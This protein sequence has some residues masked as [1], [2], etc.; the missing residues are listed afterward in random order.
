M[1]SPFFSTCFQL[2]PSFLPQTVAVKSSAALEEILPFVKGGFVFFYLLSH[3]LCQ[4]PQRADGGPLPERTEGRLAHPHFL[5]LLTSRHQGFSARTG[6][7]PETD[8]GETE[9]KQAK[10]RSPV[11]ARIRGFPRSCRSTGG[12]RRGRGDRK[13]AGNQ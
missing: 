7:E 6:A 11:W 13:R 9:T 1:Q 10:G 8:S 3:L 12:A 4:I 2:P 5:S